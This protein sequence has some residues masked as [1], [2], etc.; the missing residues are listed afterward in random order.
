[1]TR[2]PVPYKH[3]YRYGPWGPKQGVVVHSSISRVAALTQLLLVLVAVILKPYF[4]LSWSKI[5]EVSK[6]FSLWRGQVPLLSEAP[7]ELKSLS[8]TKENPPLS[9]SWKV[10]V[11]PGVSIHSLRRV[12]RCRDGRAL[13]RVSL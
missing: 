6:L 11:L 2:Q 5:N 8:L 7:L 3:R 9:L 13:R 10:V 4:H 1:M 12:R